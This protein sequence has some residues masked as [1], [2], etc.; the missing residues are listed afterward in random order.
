[1]VRQLLSNDNTQSEYSDGYRF[2]ETVKQFGLE[3]NFVSITYNVFCILV[4]LKTKIFYV[5]VL[6]P[7]FFK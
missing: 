1:M 2:N 7:V 4:P 5:F 6:L 3:S